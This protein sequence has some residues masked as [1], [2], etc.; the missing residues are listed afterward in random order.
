MKN[1]IPVIAASLITIALASGVGGLTPAAMKA[2][3]EEKIAPKDRGSR[4]YSR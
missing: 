4:R 1:L 2:A 3:R